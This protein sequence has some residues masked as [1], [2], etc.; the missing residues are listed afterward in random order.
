[1]S[2]MQSPK[3]D[4]SLPVLSTVGSAYGSFF[5]NARYLPAVLF[6]PFLMFCAFWALFDFYEIEFL[7]FGEIVKDG[8]NRRRLTG[9][10]LMVPLLLTFPFSLIAVNWHR[11]LVLGPANS[12]VRWM[13][14]LP[15]SY[16]IYHGYIIF[17]VIASFVF[18]VFISIV[19]SLIVSLITVGTMFSFDHSF[20]DGFPASPFRWL[21]YALIFFL[22]VNP[23]AWAVLFGR[24][25]FVFPAVALNEKYSFFASYRHSRG[26][27]FAMPLGLLLCIFPG[28]ALMSVSSFSVYFFDLHSIL[29]THEPRDL[30]EPLGEVFQRELP[31][32]LAVFNVAIA[33]CCSLVSLSFVTI[34]FQ[35][36]SGWVPEQMGE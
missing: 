34:A 27:T 36:C 29:A 35:K 5:R 26:L 19:E 22:L 15:R 4:R 28:V 20:G 11:L 24:F 32:W 33:G 23:T 16:W 8:E 13:Y 7:E 21:P 12:S 31:S 2:D 25:F 3:T 1:M 10:S 17:V 30:F 18:F 9:V 14:F 6:Q